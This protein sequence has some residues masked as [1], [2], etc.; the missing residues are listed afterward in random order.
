MLIHRAGRVLARL[1]IA[2][3][4][5]M[6]ML[7]KATELHPDNE[8]VLVE[9]FLHYVRVAERRAA[10]QISLRLAKIGTADKYAWWSVMSILLQVR[11]PTTSDARLLLSLAERQIAAHF[12]QVRVARGISHT[13]ESTAGTTR[14]NA[15]AK[16]KAKA[17]EKASDGVDQT[18]ESTCHFES[19]DE[20]HLVARFLE[21]NAL[22]AP[23]VPLATALSLPSF[24]SSE[25]MTARQ[26]LLAHFGSKEGDN[27]CETSLGLELW[28]RKIELRHGS[29]AGGEWIKCWDRL[30]ASLQK[31]SVRAT[32]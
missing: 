24:T 19:A 29:P 30:N 14:G 20:F 21:L 28:R 5:I 9:A 26:A 6:S 13:S 31:G 27:W 12:D 2:G 4:E 7:T 10:Q 25:G 11:D 15:E 23:S 16:G 1:E 17:Q 18:L 22:H 8:Q 32:R 3:D